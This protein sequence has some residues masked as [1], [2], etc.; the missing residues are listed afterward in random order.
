MASKKM[1]AHADTL[2]E[3]LARMLGKRRATR[4]RRVMRESGLPVEVLLDLAIEMLDLASR[5]LCA[6][7]ISR[8]AV[9]LGAARWRNV[10]AEE[11]SEVLRK[12]AQA[13]W[14]RYRREQKSSKDSKID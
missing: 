5:R 6:G 3:E 7:P 9:G 14:A 12:A 4:L 2:T 10:S 13:R 11:R 8:T 1:Q